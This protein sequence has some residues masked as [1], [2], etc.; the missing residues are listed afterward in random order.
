MMR[1]RSARYLALVSCLVLAVACSNSDSTSSSETTAAED[2]ATQGL[3]EVP[4]SKFV[5]KTS[6]PE[7][8]VLAKDNVFSPQYITISPGTK[9]VF[10][11]EG[12]NPHNVIPAEPQAFEQ[13]ATDDLQPEEQDQIIFDEPG[14]YPYY[15][16]L[17]GTPKKGMNG[18]IQVAE[19]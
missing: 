12:R 4:Q 2:S 13:I 10:I 8:T 17:H 3:P 16:S 5:D 14:I 19:S 15:C 18:R 6:Q 7:V 9:V 11:N 1:L